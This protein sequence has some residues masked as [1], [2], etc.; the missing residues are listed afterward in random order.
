MFFKDELSDSEENGEPFGEDELDEEGEPD[1]EE[2]EEEEDLENV[3]IYKGGGED[4][5]EDTDGMDYGEEEGDEEEDGEDLEDEGDIEDEDDIGDV[6][7]IKKE[8]NWKK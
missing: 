5:V 6:K 2:D 4:D 3:E 1:F 7:P 8:E